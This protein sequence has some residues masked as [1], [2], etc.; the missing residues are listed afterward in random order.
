MFTGLVAE[1]G[2]VQSLA[3]QGESYHLTVSA[4]KV[5]ANLKIGDSVAVN[6]ACLTVVRLDGG[7][8]TA[9]VMPETVR[10]TNIGQLR[11]GDKVNLERTLRLCDGLDGHI[12]SGHVEGQ[13]V[14]AARRPEGIAM[15]VTISAPPELLKYIIKKGS[16]AIDGISL[17]VTQTTDTDF[18]VSLIPHTAKETT[19]GFKDVGDKVNLETDI[20]GK[21]VERMLSWDKQQDGAALL[22]KNTLLENGFM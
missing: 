4:A 11:V 1:L 2:T 5:M 15:V 9:D 3:R 14:I 16:V 20:I 12:V 13:G 10:L 21:Y 22:D 8:F 19:L 18:S 6:G 17:T 7:A